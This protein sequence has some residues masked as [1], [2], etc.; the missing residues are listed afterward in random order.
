MKNYL[1]D[2]RLGDLLV[3]SGL[4]TTKQ[5]FDAVQAPATSRMH[6]GQ[7]LVRCGFLR[8]EHMLSGIAAQSVIKDRLLDPHTASRTLSLSC[9]ANVGFD[10]AMKALGI[11]QPRPSNRLGELF[12]AAG[13][14][15]SAR[16]AAAM[17]VSRCTG[18]PLGHVLVLH[19]SI[20]ESLLAM[21]LDLQSMIRKN[22]LSRQRAITLLRNA[23]VADQDRSDETP[24][25]QHAH[26]IRLG[27]LLVNAGLLARSEVARVIELG[28]GDNVPIGEL[29]VRFA[30]VR[31]ELIDTALNLQQMVDN[32]FLRPE[33]AARCLSYI[34]ATGARMSEALVH[35]GLIRV[36]R[37]RVS[38]ERLI[39]NCESALTNPDAT[40]GM[41][42]RV[43]KRRIEMRPGRAS[44]LAQTAR[45]ERADV[46][47]FRHEAMRTY[48]KLAQA[49]YECGNFS[50]AEWLCERIVSLREESGGVH[51]IRLVNDLINLA[52]TYRAQE[53]LMQAES[54]MIRAIDVL[55][56]AGTADSVRLAD[57]LEMLSLLYFD[58]NMLDDAEPL[59]QRALTLKEMRLSAQHPSVARSMRHY[60]RL[61]KKMAAAG[62]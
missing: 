60:A 34:D 6:L 51:D 39:G 48:A 7:S 19:G 16:L 21:V 33:Q 13:T 25:G 27:D 2:V 12:L 36:A 62:R 4:V 58:M 61:L 42:D 15:P 43:H 59:L 29:L 17:E 24:S 50:E 30:N 54:A 23:S 49:H 10:E 56:A 46:K 28:I 40:F 37:P 11:G 38:R 47:H 53:K 18:I 26:L 35:L 14:V 45:F 52:G 9:R 8:H 44:R 1:T 5:I 20:S 55:Q 57:C 3:A 41:A 31:R 22:S 32:K